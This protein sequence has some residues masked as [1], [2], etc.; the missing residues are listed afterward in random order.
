MLLVSLGVRFPRNTSANL[1]FP[2]C[3]AE[4]GKSHELLPAKF[5]HSTISIPTSSLRVVRSYQVNSQF[6]TIHPI[7]RQASVSP[8]RSSS[9]SVIASTNHVPPMHALWQVLHR[10]SPSSG[11]ATTKDL[12]RF[13]DQRTYPTDMNLPNAGPRSEISLFIY[14]DENIV[15]WERPEDHE[16]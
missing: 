12:S 15:P 5:Y 6:L 9:G 13:V 8:R 14:T 1:S 7:F 16:N 3:P 10:G 2:G 4:K 11:C